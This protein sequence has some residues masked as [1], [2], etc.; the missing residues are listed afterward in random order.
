MKKF[1]FTLL[2]VL[3][4]LPALSQPPAKVVVETVFEQQLTR[5]TRMEGVV[6]LA[7][8][9]G[10]SPEVSGLIETDHLREG[11]R[12][13]AGTPLLRL[14]TDFLNKQL[15]ITEKQLAQVQVKID[16]VR[17]NLQRHEILLQ[18]DAT[19]EK[20]FDDLTDALRELVLQEAIVKTTLEK[21]VLEKHKSVIRAPFEGLILEKYKYTGEWVAPGTAIALLGSTSDVVVEVA[22]PENLLRYIHIGHVVSV[23]LPP[24]DQYFEAPVVLITPVADPKSKTFE[25]QIGLPDFDGVTQNLSATVD[26]PS[27]QALTLK[28]VRRDARVTHN[29]QDFI[30][31]VK[32]GK[33]QMLPFPIAAYTG[34]FMGTEAPHVVE[35]MAV[36][37]D[38]NDR[39]RPDQPVEV[40][41]RLGS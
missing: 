32:D 18:Q 23:H 3:I 10:L 40:V 6:A 38:G 12:V 15:I 21:L 16:N 14:N 17:K 20:V 11:Q 35:G 9:A 36:V 25:V 28:M 26:I 29:N 4:A 22:I 5:T 19:S 39:L 2:L 30:F 37:V 8:K 31:V 7:V 27:S 13:T 1:S 33:A 34:Q 24:L 41:D